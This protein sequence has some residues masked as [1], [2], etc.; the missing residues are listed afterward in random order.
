M[1][2]YYYT[3]RKIQ[4]V[5]MHDKEK[6]VYSLMI[7]DELVDVPQELFHKIFKETSQ[8][9]IVDDSKDKQRDY[10]NSMDFVKDNLQKMK[11]FGMQKEQ[12]KEI[13]EKM[14]NMDA[15]PG[16]KEALGPII[17]ELFDE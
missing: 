1:K 3:P 15:L 13:V 14:I 10:I 17:D 4:S 16:M 2:K 11:Q 5:P 8:V 9:E 6:N 12:L 7:D